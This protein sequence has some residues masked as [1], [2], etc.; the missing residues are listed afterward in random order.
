M[1]VSPDRK[2]Y[3]DGFILTPLEEEEEDEDEDD[4]DEDVEDELVETEL[5]E[6]ETVE[7]Y[8]S[9]P[10]AMVAW[11]WAVEEPK[12]ALSVTICVT[13]SFVAV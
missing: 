13:L 7:A 2:L 5:V 10:C 8:A 9:S 6:T 11:H 3:A 12:V 4:E 1:W